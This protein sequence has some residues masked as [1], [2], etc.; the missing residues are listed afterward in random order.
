[1]I[2]SKDCDVEDLEYDDLEDTKIDRVQTLCFIEQVKLS[3][4]SMDSYP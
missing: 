4:L 3:K 2:S 1:M